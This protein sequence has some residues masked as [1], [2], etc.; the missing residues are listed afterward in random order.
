MIQWLLPW[1]LAMPSQSVASQ[2]KSTGSPGLLEIL[3]HREAWGTSLGMFALGYVWYFLLS[4][5]PTYLINERS[6]SQNAMA[7]FGSLPF[8]GM[9]FT[10][11][12]GGWLSDLWIRHGGSPTLV[13]KTFLATGL[14]LC[15]ALMVPAVLVT[16]ASASLVFLIASSL[17]LGIFTSNV[18]AVTQTLAG[19]TAAGK[20]AGIQNC[21]G[22]LGGVLS[23]A[24]TGII[25]DQ[26]RSF[27]LAFAAASI[28]LVLGVF[29]YLLLIP[30]VAPLSWISPADRQLAARLG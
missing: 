16:N 26:T 7:I 10:S 24:L 1:T 23:P 22:N 20:W 15:A 2:E 25:V 18:W 8:W 30:K 5:L 3:S 17:S 9:A 21:V 11:I 28:V 13:R 19:P 29:A 12:A 27:S 4:W 6:F 14:L